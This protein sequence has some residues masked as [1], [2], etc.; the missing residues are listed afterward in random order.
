MDFQICYF[1]LSV[2]RLFQFRGRVCLSIQLFFPS[3]TPL[4]SAWAVG[5]QLCAF[6]LSQHHQELRLQKHFC[7]HLFLCPW[8]LFWV[9]SSGRCSRLT[10]LVEMMWVVRGFGAKTAL[11]WKMEN[12][13]KRAD[14]ALLMGRKKQTK[15]NKPKPE[16]TNKQ[17]NKTQQ[18]EPGKTCHYQQKRVDYE[19]A[20]SFDTMNY[21]NSYFKSFILNSQR[22]ATKQWDPEDRGNTRRNQSN[23]G[24]KE[25]K[26]LAHPLYRNNCISYYLN[27]TI[28]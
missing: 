11:T 20:Q 10:S 13:L 27:N 19:C 17:T 24:G 9:C 6:R 25:I 12:S 8:L 22:R 16:Q 2:V 4:N 5:I 26:R 1:W 14:V 21:F 15:Q 18:V 23:K 7:P 3:T 28:L